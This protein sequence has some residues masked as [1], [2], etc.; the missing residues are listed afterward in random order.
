[1]GLIWWRWRAAVVKRKL[2]Q[3]LKL[4]PCLASLSHDVVVGT[5]DDA[6]LFPQ[7]VTI[8]LMMPVKLNDDDLGR[9]LSEHEIFKIRP[10][11]SRIDLAC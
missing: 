11:D 2:Q 5:K 7:E 8:S 9:V 10:K 4:L 6:M 1:M 3:E